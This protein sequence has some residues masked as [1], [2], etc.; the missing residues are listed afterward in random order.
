MIQTFSRVGNY[1]AGLACL[2]QQSYRDKHVLKAT[3]AVSVAWS[4]LSR[5]KER[6][7]AGGACCSSLPAAGGSEDQVAQLGSEVT[8]LWYELQQVKIASNR[9]AN[10]SQREADIGK[11]REPERL[12]NSL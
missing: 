5:D 8:R 9:A 1:F 4:W 12:C 7:A 6:H 11:V 2:K 3:S 10:S